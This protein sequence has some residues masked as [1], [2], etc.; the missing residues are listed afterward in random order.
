VTECSICR[1]EFE[2]DD[3]CVEGLIGLIPFAF[4]VTCKAGIY[5]WACQQWGDDQ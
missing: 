1:V 5:E 2:P 4:C 3:E